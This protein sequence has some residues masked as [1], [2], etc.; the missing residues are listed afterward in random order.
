MIFVTMPT[1]LCRFIVHYLRG[2]PY[3]HAIILTCVLAAVG[4]AVT[5]Q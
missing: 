5:T 4:C 1:V 3:S 2:R